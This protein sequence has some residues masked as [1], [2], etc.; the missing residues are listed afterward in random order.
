MMIRLPSSIELIFFQSSCGNIARNSFSEWLKKS[1]EP[2]IRSTV[3]P[4][5]DK[6]RATFDGELDAGLRRNRGFVDDGQLHLHGIDEI[7]PPLLLPA[8]DLQIQQHFPSAVLLETFADRRS[9]Q[10]KFKPGTE[11][12]LHDFGDVN[13]GQ[14]RQQFGWNYVGLHIAP[15]WHGLLA[16]RRNPMRIDMRVAFARQYQSHCLAFLVKFW[17]ACGTLD[18]LLEYK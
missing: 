10:S 12:V 18:R 7:P 15:V 5:S 3:V 9:H 11:F 16:A 6:G 4:S 2:K 14:L 13:V 1:I 8:A 17:P